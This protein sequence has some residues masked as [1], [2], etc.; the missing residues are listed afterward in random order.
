LGKSGTVWN[1]IFHEQWFSTFFHL[2]RTIFCQ[3]FSLYTITLK[4]QEMNQN[5]DV[6]MSQAISGMPRPVMTV[7]SD[8]AKAI[9]E[10]TFSGKGKI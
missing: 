8:I 10:N 4:S 7:V 1:L 2:D 5:C 9:L 6:Y 3:Y